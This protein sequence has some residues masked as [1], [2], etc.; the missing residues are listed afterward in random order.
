[1]PEKCTCGA[2]LVPDA[3]FCHKCGRAVREIVVEA[4]PEVSSPV[5]APAAAPATPPQAEPLPPVGFHNKVAVRIA[6][7]VAM[8]AMLLAGVTPILIVPAWVA[9]G[10]TAVQL[11]RKR[12]GEFL[13]VRAGMTLGWITGVIMF[14][15]GMVS[16]TLRA[17][18][19]IGNGGLAAMFR[20]QL[21]KS[22]D[23]NVKEFL[24]MLDTPS[25]LALLLIVLL[26]ML[27]LFITLFSVAGGAL[28]AKFGGRGGERPA[29]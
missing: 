21:K 29:A 13:N 2:Q 5:P 16:L 18:P 12:T 10:F 25:G 23:P 26:P 4:E 11:Y 19:G 7:W 1:M 24:Q 22:P 27:F 9:A 15:L 17:I 3:V 14:V 28:G 8:V 20:E 6:S